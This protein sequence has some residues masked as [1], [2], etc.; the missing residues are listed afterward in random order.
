MA[1][2]FLR[3]EVLRAVVRGAVSDGPPVVRA[4][5][6]SVLDPHQSRV[7][8]MRRVA[9]VAI[10]RHIALGVVAFSESYA[11]ERNLD[12]NPYGYVRRGELTRAR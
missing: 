7:L 5:L 6:T 1:A 10:L 8:H 3:T 4:P 12:R 9:R 11:L 2:Q